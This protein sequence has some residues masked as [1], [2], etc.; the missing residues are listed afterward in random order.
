M[1]H[2]TQPARRGLSSYNEEKFGKVGADLLA[3]QYIGYHDYS[4]M[5]KLRGATEPAADYRR[6]AEQMRRHLNTVWRDP[7]AKLYHH[8][9][10]PDGSWLD[11]RQMVSFLLRR[12]VV[13]AERA[14]AVLDHLRAV[15]QQSGVEMNTYY[16]LEFYRYGRPEQG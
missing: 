4:E 1:N 13:P 8:Y 9:V 11:D 16:P 7:K 3:G 12:D 2:P 10:Q 14:S 6:R 5:L 15:H